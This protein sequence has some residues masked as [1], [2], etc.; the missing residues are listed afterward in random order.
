MLRFLLIMLLSLSAT[1]LYADNIDDIMQLSGINHELN[2]LHQNIDASFPS[3]A[4]NTQAAIKNAMQESFASAPMQTMIA[5]YLRTHLDKKTS[6]AS[7]VWLRSP[8][9]VKIT[10]LESANNSPEAQADM[11]KQIP[12]LLKNTQRFAL[13][14]ELDAAI[15][16]TQS[17]I[18]TLL[19]IQEAMVRGIMASNPNAQQLTTDE[20]HQQIVQL[21]PQI[22]AQYAILI[23]GSMAYNYQT[24]SDDEIRQYINFA[25]SPTGIHYHSAIT[26]AL[27][28]AMRSA[29]NT[30]GNTLGKLQSDDKTKDTRP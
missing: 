19:G 12:T 22:K 18:N 3:T 9:G 29:G 15:N 5:N 24:L 28:Q 1:V 26:K 30:V 13:I 2:N 23:I 16:V 20:L 21:E 10:A 25:K 14:R 7:L 6:Q 11:Q 27:D 8:L 17:T 4:N